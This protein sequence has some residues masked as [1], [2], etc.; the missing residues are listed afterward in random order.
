MKDKNWR[1]VFHT[2]AGADINNAALVARV[3]KYYPVSD[4]SI[5]FERLDTY[6][7][8]FAV[9]LKLHSSLLQG[10]T[11]LNL[12]HI[13]SKRIFS[14]D[15]K[16]FEPVNIV[17]EFDQLNEAV[18]STQQNTQDS[19]S[20][21]AQEVL[22]DER[23]SEQEK[24]IQLPDVDTITSLLQFWMNSQSV[25]PPYVLH[26]HHLV[27]QRYFDYERFIFQ[28][29]QQFTNKLML[30][31]EIEHKN[32]FNQLFD[33]AARKSKQAQ[34][35]ACA[36]TQ[37]FLILNGGPGTGK[38]Y[39]VARIL[40]MLK[41]I[42]PSMQISLAAPTGKAAHRLS[43]SLQKT[44][45]K[46]KS[47]EHLANICS[48][49]PSKAHTI[50]SLIG[51]EKGSAA[52]RRSQ[53]NPMPCDLL[54]I[55]EFSMVDSALFAKVLNAC[56]P[57]CRLILVG[58]AQQLPSVEP[59]NLLHDLVANSKDVKSFDMSN[60]I[61]ELTGTHAIVEGNSDF[62]HIVTLADNHRSIKNINDLASS[63]IEK[64]VDD[65]VKR[66]SS[67][68]LLPDNIRL[69]D[70]LTQQNRWLQSF[71]DEYKNVLKQAT[72]VQEL[73]ELFASFRVLCPIRKGIHG[74]EAINQWFAT[75]VKA[76]QGKNISSEF[77][78]G[79]PIIIIEND[80]STG[81]SNGD[82]G[83]IWKDNEDETQLIAH[84]ERDN[85]EK[86]DKVE[87][88]STQLRLSV[89]R[90]PKFESAFALTIHKTQGSEFDR[91]LLILPYELS[92]GC[93]RELLYTG[94]TRAKSEVTIL[95][96]E[97]TLRA[98]IELTNKRTT[99]LSLF[100]NLSSL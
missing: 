72:S 77:F 48:K 64:R 32:L 36:L 90:L 38:T 42:S 5:E 65:A 23:T 99:I 20:D 43:E 69:N 47:N 92:Q 67:S 6:K 87:R 28:K 89:N 30:N 24:G 50:Q 100:S 97:Q 40:I 21:I 2:L 17:N 58:D 60:F 86:G 45:E 96:R 59:G 1:S 8:L 11:C 79:Q 78:H 61:A 63:V 74:V 71:A 22:N 62:D 98:G 4:D 70:Y 27:I 44:L 94:I 18:K 29:V 66:L 13:A 81:L 80:P 31:V 85:L 68:G 37:Q 39:T 3:L 16:S 12:H 15:E 46:V 7:T 54:V 49:L 82:F 73:F 41:S 95:A 75:N 51:T 10:H 14:E 53:S 9:L 52:V 91:V 35:V 56:K 25:V 33:K 55:D 34:A 93:T 83:I 57:N 76:E 26:K 84:I 19:L 88:T